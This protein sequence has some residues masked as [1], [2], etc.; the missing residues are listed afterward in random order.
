MER[1]AVLYDPGKRFEVVVPEAALWWQVAPWPVQAQQLDRIRQAMTLSTVWLGIVPLGV[2]API[3]RVHGFS[4]FDE[5]AD[6]GDP[7]VIVET[8]TLTLTLS[9]PAA[10]EEYREA[11]RRLQAVAVTGPEALEI[12]ARLEAAL[13]R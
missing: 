12:L 9:E 8:L 11:F 6:D 10:V 7:L 13:A 1:Q 5:P 3:F 2:E 4:M